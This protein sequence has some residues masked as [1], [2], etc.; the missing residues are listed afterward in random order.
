MKHHIVR[1][2]SI[3]DDVNIRESERGQAKGAWA[4]CKD[5]MAKKSCLIGSTDQ[6]GLLFLASHEVLLQFLAGCP[7]CTA[8]VQIEVFSLSD[9]A[10]QLVPQDGTGDPGMLE[11]YRISVS[12][13]D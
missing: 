12:R 13:E 1:L 4:F 6:G 2:H 10:G 9:A 3:I 7:T 5:F 11:S 8:A